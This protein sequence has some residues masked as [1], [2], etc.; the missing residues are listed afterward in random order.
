MSRFF[1]QAGL[2]A[3][4]VASRKGIINFLLMVFVDKLEGFVRNSGELFAEKNS[5]G[6][7]A[8]ESMT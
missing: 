3:I 1:C 2:L 7:E 8:R 5:P 4:V 6:T